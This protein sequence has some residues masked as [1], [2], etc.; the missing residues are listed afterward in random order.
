MAVILDSGYS[1][2]PVYDKTPDTIKGVLYSKD[3]LPYIGKDDR[4]AWQ[5]LLREAYFVPES[6]MLD[7]LLEDFRLRGTR[8]WRTSSRKSWA[9]STT[10]MTRPT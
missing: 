1:R 4:P 9:T 3:L 8:P 6:R 7:D 5:S 2:I 10:N